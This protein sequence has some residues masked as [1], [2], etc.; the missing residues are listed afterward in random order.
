[1]CVC[2]YLCI[3][4]TCFSLL[5][6]YIYIGKSIDPE[7]SK[8]GGDEK[9]STNAY[10]YTRFASLYNDHG[11]TPPRQ[12]IIDGYSGA[13][14]D[15]FYVVSFLMEN[16][17]S[18]LNGDFIPQVMNQY[19]GRPVEMMKY[20]EDYVTDA[21]DAAMIAIETIPL[22]PPSPPSPQLQLANGPT[23]IENSP[24]QVT[25]GSPAVIEA[26]TAMDTREINAKRKH[27][28]LTRA[29]SQKNN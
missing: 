21:A 16:N 26:A 29:Q 1:M 24:L 5:I 20:V 4:Q 6:L 23:T 12:E 11:L 3:W 13:E 7:G 18:L 8:V 14:E 27:V 9:E 25:D 15:L 19:D 28:P 17:Q 10:D 22:A 2:V